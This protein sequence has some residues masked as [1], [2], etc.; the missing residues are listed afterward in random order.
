[1]IQNGE[2]GKTLTEN[3]KLL[4]LRFLKTIPKTIVKVQSIKDLI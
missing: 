2:I 4:S 3:H 1:M